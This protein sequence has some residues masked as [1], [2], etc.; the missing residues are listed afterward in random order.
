MADITHSRKRYKSYLEPC[1]SSNA[2][3]RA[4]KYRWQ[5][6]EGRPRPASAEGHVDGMQISAAQSAQM[7]AQKT[8]E[9]NVSLPRAWPCKL[10]L[11]WVMLLLILVISV[12]R[13]QASTSANKRQQIEQ[14]YLVNHVV[15][16]LLGYP[17]VRY[18]DALKSF[19]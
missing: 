15:T 7:P 13:Q 14:A 1:N 18:N 9:F 3:P 12:K 11:I 5:A 4:S 10:G 19:F 6:S 2:V 17:R 16:V 8:S